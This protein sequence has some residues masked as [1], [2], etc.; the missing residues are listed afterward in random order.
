[1][2]SAPPAKRRRGR[3]RIHPRPPPA[4]KMSL[5]ELPAN[6]LELVAAHLAPA[7]YTAEEGWPSPLLTPFSVGRARITANFGQ[8]GRQGGVPDNVRD[9]MSLARSCKAV[10]R[11]TGQVLDRVVGLRLDASDEKEDEAGQKGKGKGKER[12]VGR[13]GAG[14]P[15]SAS[16]DSSGSGMDE[17]RRVFAVRCMLGGAS[18]GPRYPNYYDDLDGSEG[19]DSDAGSLDG[20]DDSD[21]GQGPDVGDGPGGSAM[22]ATHA[23]RQKR[24]EGSESGSDEANRAEQ[25]A[26][27]TAEQEKDREA[28]WKRRDELDDDSGEL[29]LDERRAR[30][31][32]V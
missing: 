22:Y 25:D 10:R 15:S 5:C 20:A 29:T 32:R 7:H 3:P 28:E 16:G 21:G 4:K 19:S 26:K 9:L 1:M 2:P 8:K 31:K 11:A 17:G 14:S 6:V 24:S 18:A 13:G 23:R 30:R 12:D 27:A